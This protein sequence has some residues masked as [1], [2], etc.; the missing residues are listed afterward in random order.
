MALLTSE[1]SQFALEPLNNV[2]NTSPQDKSLEALRAV[3]DEVG[4][5]K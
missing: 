1:L 3:D 2:F 5:E 4:A